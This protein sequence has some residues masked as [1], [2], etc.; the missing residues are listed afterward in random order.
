[1]AAAYVI[2]TAQFYRCIQT[3]NF[4][5]AAHYIT[6][7]PSPRRRWIIRCVVIAL[8]LYALVVMLAIWSDRF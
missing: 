7:M 8:A 1:M 6:N 2:L 4:T 3:E 5:R